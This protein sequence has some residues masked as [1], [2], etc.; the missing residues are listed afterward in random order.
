MEKR[1]IDVSEHQGEINWEKVKG[2]IAF[3]IL[4]LGWIGNNNNHTLDKQFERNYSECK[5]LGIPVGVYVY[6]YCKT[7]SKIV[8]GAIWV[9]EQLK[10]K[11]LELPVYLDMEDDSIIESGKQELTDMVIRFNSEIEESGRY[12]GVYANKYWFNT[13][14]YKD[15]LSKMYSC[16]VAQYNNVCDLEIN[17][18]DMWQFTNS[19]KI[20]GIQGNVDMNI[21]YRDLV[22]EIVNYTNDNKKS[23]EELAIEVI[24]GL[25]GNGEERKN[26]LTSAGY[27]YDDVQKLVNEKM[28]NTTNFIEYKVKRGDNLIKIAKMYNTKWHIIY[29]DNKD[30]IGNN[31]NIIKVN[32][33]LKI[34]K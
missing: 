22:S 9:L 17:N 5:R 7:E 24:D 2:Q 19:G 29:N 21:L 34:R 28:K 12:A 6:N 16:W 10:N 31:P 13:Y 8:D 26:R 30:V 15:I 23:I 18:K 1:G 20:D 32:Q 3:A 33:I 11:V 4:R 27:N 14:L 25:W